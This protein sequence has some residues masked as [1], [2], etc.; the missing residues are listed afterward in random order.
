MFPP[1]AL[2]L[3]VAT[4]S[5]LPNLSKG[6]GAVALARANK[7]SI[8]GGPGIRPVS[9]GGADFSRRMNQRMSSAQGIPSA[10]AVAPVEPKVIKDTMRQ[11]KKDRPQYQ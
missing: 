10:R 2:I 3:K 7:A 11:I 8:L 9:V 1:P 4:V 6:S 5:V